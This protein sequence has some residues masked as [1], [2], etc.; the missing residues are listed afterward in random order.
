[1]AGRAEWTLLGKEEKQP[2][3]A[4]ELPP[5]VLPV[6]GF[7]LVLTSALASSKHAPLKTRDLGKSADDISILA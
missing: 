3:V 5:T 2:C 6:S 1:M 4:K 7:W